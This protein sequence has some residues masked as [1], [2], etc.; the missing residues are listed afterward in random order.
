MCIIC[1]K[2]AG[3]KAPT[4][5]IIRTMANNNPDGFGMMWVEDNILKY[6]HTFNVEDIINQSSK[7]DY[8]VPA[9]Y[10][11]RIATHGSVKKENC[12]PFI[13]KQ[14]AIGFAHNGMLSAVANENDKT[15]SETAFRRLLIPVIE[16]YGINS[17]E[18][19][20]AVN[21]IIGTSKFV[22]LDYKGNLRYFGQ[23]IK[24]KKLLYSNE[25]FRTKR[26]RKITTTKG[27][28]YGYGNVS[29]NKALGS[30]QVYSNK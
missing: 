14:N 18:L 19:E 16:C 7:L 27:G 23:F 10:H 12:H 15:D 3:V 28:Y 26:E 25:Y 30:R 24:H 21:C 5:T 22:F 11:F 9:V 20:L 1:I 13:D 4:E 29:W 8:K 17:E 2:Q 6:F